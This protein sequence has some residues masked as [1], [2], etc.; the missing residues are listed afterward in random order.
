MKNTPESAGYIQSTEFGGDL[1]GAQSYF[2]L[3][4]NLYPFKKEKKEDQGVK[5]SFICERGLLF[6]FTCTLFYNFQR[7]FGQF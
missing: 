7:L 1:C 4:Q 3:Y 5:H 6:L 2:L